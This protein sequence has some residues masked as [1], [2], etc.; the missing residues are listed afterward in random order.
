MSSPTAPRAIPAKRRWRTGGH[1]WALAWK[2]SPTAL[3]A[4]RLTTPKADADI[5]YYELAAARIGNVVVV[6]EWSSM[7][8]PET[9][10][11]WVWY[12]E[13]LDVA[14]HRAV[15]QNLRT[16]ES[17]SQAPVLLTAADL[18]VTQQ[19]R[20]WRAD[21]GD[22]GGTTDT[23]LPA[24]EGRQFEDG[25]RVRFLASEPVSSQQAAVQWVYTAGDPAIAAA[26]FTDAVDWIS[27]CPRRPTG[28]LGKAAVDEK[29]VGTGDGVQRVYPSLTVGDLDQRIA[30]GQVGKIVTI[31][32]LQRTTTARADEA[33]LQKTL[34]RA[35]TLLQPAAQG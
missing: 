24:L 27:G 25:Q 20:P 13:T 7:G 8:K 23:C 21:D 12:A 6:L 18:P 33:E 34:E 15:E 19:D 17:T 31:V 16:S 9:P 4:S 26:T 11:G 14:A 32:V 10:G 30:V 3:R 35:I 1:T 29:L 2:A 22:A 28:A 5:S